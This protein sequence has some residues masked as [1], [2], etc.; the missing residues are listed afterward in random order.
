MTINEWEILDQI[1][2]KMGEHNPNSPIYNQQHVTYKMTD[3]T[4]TI[5]DSDDCEF[6]QFYIDKEGTEIILQCKNFDQLMSL[7]N[8]V[9]IGGIVIQ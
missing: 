7:A 4:I 9:T 2:G 8:I 5:V 1:I 6:A 3:Y